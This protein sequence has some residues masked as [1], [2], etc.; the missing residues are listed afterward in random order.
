M[1]TAT[2]ACCWVLIWVLI[3]P[4]ALANGD[5]EFGTAQGLLAGELTETSVIV[6]SRLTSGGRDEHGEIQGRPG[7][8]RFELSQ[9]P[10]FSD[11]DTTDWLGAVPENDH[12]VKKLIDDLEPVRQ[13]KSKTVQIDFSG[14]PCGC[15]DCEDSNE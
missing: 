6:Q 13:T 3:L 14:P 15:R 9:D 4:A 2:Q 12:I 8:A 11:F 7:V 10:E 1:K 5:L